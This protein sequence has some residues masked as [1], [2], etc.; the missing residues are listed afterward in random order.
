MVDNQGHSL[1][2]L[3]KLCVVRSVVHYLKPTDENTMTLLQA[4]FIEHVHTMS[5][6][7][8]HNLPFKL[9]QRG[10]DAANKYAEGQKASI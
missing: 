9:T 3:H 2:L 8:T 10:V 6:D 7:E 4:G 1:E 5:P